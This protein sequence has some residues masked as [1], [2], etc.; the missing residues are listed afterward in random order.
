MFS[1]IYFLNKLE[2]TCFFFFS[3]FIHSLPFFK[4]DSHS[5]IIARVIC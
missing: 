2:K 3:F 5:K 1:F 4:V